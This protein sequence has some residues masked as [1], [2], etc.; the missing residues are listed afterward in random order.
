METIIF[1]R[2]KREAFRGKLEV[3]GGSVNSSVVRMC[4]ERADGI[5]I[6]LNGKISANGDCIIDVPPMKILE[7]GEVGKVKIEVIVEGQS[8]FIIHEG[9]FEIRDFMKLSTEEGIVNAEPA[10]KSSP[11]LTFMKIDEAE[12]DDDF[13]S[14]KRKYYI[15]NLD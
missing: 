15:Q 13:E 5:S 10:A 3:D 1:Y 6:F 8:Y 12:K 11:K 7:K 14:F 2:D 9:N 4:L